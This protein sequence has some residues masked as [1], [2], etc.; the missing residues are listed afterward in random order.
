MPHSPKFIS[1]VLLFKCSSVILISINNR[2]VKD[3]IPANGMYI[4]MLTLL[5][6][7]PQNIISQIISFSLAMSFFI[8]DG[9]ILICFHNGSSVCIILYIHH[10]PLCCAVGIYQFSSIQ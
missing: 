2:S 1:N 5:V 9:S 4:M 10:R 7:N 8:Y 3:A 6:A